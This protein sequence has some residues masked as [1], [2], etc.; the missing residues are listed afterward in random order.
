VDL[1]AL[2]ALILAIVVGVKSLMDR[3]WPML[4]VAIALI[5]LALSGQFHVNINN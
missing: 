3:S 4:L 2:V 1:L 5:C